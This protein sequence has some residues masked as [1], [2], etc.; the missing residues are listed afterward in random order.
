MQGREPKV[1]DNTIAHHVHLAVAQREIRYARQDNVAVHRFHANGARVLLDTQLGYFERLARRNQ[2]LRNAAGNLRP[3]RLNRSLQ[4]LAQIRIVAS[5][6]LHEIRCKIRT[7]HTHASR[8][9][10]SNTKKLR[11]KFQPRQNGARRKHTHTQQTLTQM[12][13]ANS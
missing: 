8:S 13:L 1:D 2:Q 9:I 6:F 5:A 10:A 7:K 12:M 4:T 11:W 3:H